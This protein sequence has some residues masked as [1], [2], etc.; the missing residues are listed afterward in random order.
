MHITCEGRSFDFLPGATPQHLWDMVR[1][2]RPKEAAVLAEINGAV[3]DFQT[4]FQ[5]GG[6]VTW[7]PLDSPKAHYAYVRSAILLLVS[8][9]KELFGEAADVKVKHSLG[10]ALYCEFKD[11]H[12]PLQ[13]ELDRLDEVMRHMVKEG[14]P[15]TKISVGMKRA[16]A[17][18]R[19]T[20][21]TDEMELLS[22]LEMDSVINVDQCGSVADYFFGPML[23]DMSY[24][25]SFRL[26]AYAPGFLLQLPPA[27]GIDLIDEG[28]ADPLFAKVFLESQNW[29]ELIGCQ[30][31]A[32]LN[33]SM[34]D[35][36]IYDYIS[37][38]EALHEKKL[39]EL[40][41]IICRQNPKLRLIC[42]AGP[43]SS[44]KTTFLKRLIVHLRVN[45]VHP[46]MLSLDD[47]F[48]NRDEMDGKDW[49]EIHAIDLELFENTVMALLEGKKVRLP[50][51][52]FMTG[53]KEWGEEE[54]Q[55]GAGQP[56]LVEGLHALNPRLTY[57]VPG[58]QCMRIYLSALT[59]LT[60][61]DH[62]RISTSDTRLLRRMVR[63]MQFRGHSPEKTL[64][65]WKNVREGEGRNIFQFQSLANV[66]FNS[67]LLYEI[68]VLKKIVKPHLEKITPDN[69]C[70]AQ[71]QRLLEFLRPFRELDAS[72]VPDTSLL[73]EFIG[74]EG[75]GKSFLNR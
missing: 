29:T 24:V 55:L 2:D 42:T 45:G 16:M 56:I 57:F 48:Y 69:P 1:G 15:I 44:G 47:Y 21:R 65:S 23:P 43:S 40:A 61:N 74:Y 39:A 20:G 32:Q 70:Y 8:A 50:H 31:L 30:S 75:L 10:M 36:R 41:D 59:Q 26:K 63:D 52:N 46:V 53:K 6:E 7:I 27:D 22:P 64:L 33:K 12:V 38:A 13:R 14:W 34:E 49:E 68:P 71:A 4:A 35:G 51:F 72:L 58:Y 73:R 17:F 18:L 19:M 62:N 25:I 66:V 11:G 5:K 60:I 3:I 9:V 37:I 54:V 67:A 28:E